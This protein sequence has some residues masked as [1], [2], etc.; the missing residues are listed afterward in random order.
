MASNTQIQVANLDFVDI[1]QNFIN[2]LK[3]QDVLKDYNYTGSALSTLL[4]VLAYNTQ[5]NA[6]YLNMVANEMFL[7][8]ALQRSSVVSHAKLM[9]YV[10]QSAVGPVAAVNVAF[11]GVTTPTFTIPQYTKFVSTAINNKNYPFVTQD[12]LTVS[13]SNGVAYFTN[14]NIKQGTKERA[15]FTVNSTT[16]PSYTFEITDPRIDTTT[17]QVAVQQSISNSYYEVYNST[18]DFLALG[19]N[20][21]VYFLQ[22]A[23]NGN[24]Q[25]YFGDGILG[26]KLEDG[27]I[28]SIDYISTQGT[29][30]G[31]ANAF[32]LMDNIGSY[33]SVQVI[34]YAAATQGKEKESIDSI[35]FQAPKSFAA[36]GR[37]VSKNDYMSVLQQNNLGIQFDSVSVWGGE[38]NDP[39]AYGQVFIS[40]KPKGAYDLTDTQ[41]QL[42]VT[43]VLKPISV[44]TVAPTIVNPDYTYIQLNANVV[45]QSSKTSLNPVGLQ[46]KITEALYNY[47][48]NNLNTFNATLSS[49]DVLTTI[50]MVDPSIIS[51]DFTINLQKKITPAFSTPTT[52]TMF[53]NTSLK[54]G[55]YQNGIT[56]YPGMTVQDPSD[57]LSTISNVYIEEVPTFTGGVSS[58]SV[59]NP[60]YNYQSTPKVKISGDG[61][62]ATAVATIV[63]GALKS[64][65]I[66]NTGSGYTAATATIIPATGDNTGQNAAVTVNLEGQ[67][68]TLRTYYNNL[69]NVKTIVSSNVG[70]VDYINGIVTLN[71]FT[72]MGIDDPLGQLTLSV[73]PTTTIVSSTY[74]RIITIDPFDSAAIQVKT[75]AKNS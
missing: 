3:T 5:Y 32:T 53:F 6:F 23:I 28:I 49:Y 59:I 24:Y 45:Y 74:N 22:E 72:L 40:L 58:I 16:N 42:L 34:P 38:E 8:S 9:N 44:L 61:E 13:S 18:T 15:T 55:G 30:G 29:A 1:K 75:V 26:K 67:Y 21:R 60:G 10:P 36:Q 52:Y 46:S 4:D 56:S 35:K 63:N 54:K 51:S 66:A 2:Y 20:D 43:N 65:A 62:G 33:G 41:K 69:L 27:N 37:A 68:G 39:P 57:P 64:V 73:Q 48:A 47:S 11:Y 71:D 14:V 31:Y 70:K 12:V 50:K 7:D 17:L 19:P 25:I